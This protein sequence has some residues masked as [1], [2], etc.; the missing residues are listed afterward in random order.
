MEEGQEIDGLEVLVNDK[1]IEF[2]AKVK[3]DSEEDDYVKEFVM[4]KRETGTRYPV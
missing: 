3:K 2:A 1:P 4:V